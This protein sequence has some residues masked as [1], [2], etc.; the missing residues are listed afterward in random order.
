MPLQPV[1]SHILLEQYNHSGTPSYLADCRVVLQFFHVILI[2]RGA[3][4]IVEQK[5]N[6]TTKEIN[7]CENWSLVEK[8]ERERSVVL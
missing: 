6:N 2:G 3:I 1:K 8:R 5:C 4:N 7:Y